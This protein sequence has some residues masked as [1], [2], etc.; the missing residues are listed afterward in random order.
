MLASPPRRSSSS[1]ENSFK[2]KKEKK[3]Q[4]KEEIPY[5]QRNKRK[6]EEHIASVEPVKGTWMYESKTENRMLREMDDVKAE[7]V[8]MDY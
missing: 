4:R 6:W 5:E 2:L 7:S 1:T 3:K 8:E